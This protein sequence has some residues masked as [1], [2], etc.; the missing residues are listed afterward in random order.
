[1]QLGAGL[2][3]SVFSNGYPGLAM[4]P[5]PSTVPEGP[6]TI[7]QQAFGVPGPGSDPGRKGLTLAGIGTLALAGLAFIWW[8][9]PR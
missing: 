1:M 3:G 8:A 6:A 7:T 2:G 4:V 9:L 5:G